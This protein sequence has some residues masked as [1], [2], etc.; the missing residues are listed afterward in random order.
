MN[1]FETENDL[2]IQKLN[3]LITDYERALSVLVNS[4]PVWFMDVCDGDR[5]LIT[6]LV[7]IGE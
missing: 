2:E 7:K 4:N 6:K 3:Y 1:I 5:A